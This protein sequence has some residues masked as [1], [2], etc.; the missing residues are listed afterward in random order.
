MSKEISELV[1]VDGIK[2][3]KDHEWAKQEGDK[4]II[5]ISDYAQDQLGEVVFV[6][7]P[8]IGSEFET[9]DEFGTV[10][11][12]KAVSELYL[13]LGGRVAEIN[14]E[15]EDDPELVNKSPY[16]KGWIIKIEPKDLGE[17]D[18]LM[19]KDAYL[20]MLKG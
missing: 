13:P 11:S 9:G 20:N 18:Q 19:D 16:E 8:E 4:V 10:E 3:A 12:T 15:L 2:Y 7:M 1:F 5:G 6:E 14:K 17:L